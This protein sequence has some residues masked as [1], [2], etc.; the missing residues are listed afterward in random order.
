MTVDYA[1]WQTPEKHALEVYIQGV[2]LARKPNGVANGNAG[3]A[4]GGTVNLVTGASFDQP[5]FHMLIGLD[6]ASNLT[7]IP[8][9]RLKFQWTDV[10]SGFQVDPDWAFLPGAFA[11]VDFVYISGPARADT[12]TVELDNLDPGQI[13]F[14]DLGI[15]QQSHVYDQFRVREVGQPAV[16]GLTRA[17]SNNQAGILASIG[18]N[19]PA[20]GATTR[21]ASVWSG[22]AFLSCDNTAGTAS[23]T[24]QIIDPG[25][26]LGGGM[27]YGTANSGIIASMFIPAGQS[28][29]KQVSLPNGTVLVREVNGSA[30]VAQTPTTTLT[31]SRG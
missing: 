14:Y 18:A 20:G 4:A 13:L 11:S 17:G 23:I 16:V 28:D 21:Q 7:T 31:R 3:V 24:V 29:V 10:A 6:Y 1:D 15:S 9:G 30:T 5:S 22:E 26:L 25:L 8:F 12:L 27:F 2:P 19:V